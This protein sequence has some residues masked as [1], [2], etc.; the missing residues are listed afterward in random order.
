MNAMAELVRLS[1]G[2]P[3][4]PTPEH[5][6][7]AGRRAI[8]ENFTR[9]TPQPGFD[10]L[11]EAICGKFRSENGIDAAPEQIVVSCGGKHS[12]YN[13]IQ[14][15]VE[16][17]D[18]VI[19][20]QPY[21]FA[22]PEQVRRAGGKAV[23]VPTL[24]AARFQPD[25]DAVRRAITD[26]TRAIVLNSPCNPTGAVYS[27]KLLS[28]IAALAVEHDLL[29]ISDEVYEKILFDGAEHVSIGSLGS[30]ISERTV[31]INSVSKTH[32][33]TGW[34]IGYAALPVELARRVTGLQS[35]STSGPC[36][37]SQRA[38]LAAVTGQQSHINAMVHAYAQRRERL[39]ERVRRINGFSF[40]V[41]MGTFYLMADM[42]GW[43][44]RMFAGRV[45]ADADT[46]VDIVLERENV[47]LLSC[48]DFGAPCHVRFSF[49]V[50]GD[51]IDE[52][53]DRLEHLW[54][55]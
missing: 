31:T 49:A 43:G 35:V 47:Q 52:G 50:S 23:L 22:V 4:F 48:S 36:A 1:V 53:M 21:W 32:A 5:V 34:R 55:Q 54:S 46:F 37:I 33:M 44:G 7:E 10:D 26:S 24:A 40:H 30:E 15:A 11:R 39:V 3:D 28:Q 20:F 25:P 17:G 18:E 14:C 27:R 12:L 19:V 41:P 9:Y 16:P 29:V 45:V 42:S 13:V 8:A 38:A 6:K 2:E 51:A